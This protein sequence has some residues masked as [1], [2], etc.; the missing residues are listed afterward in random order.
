[1]LTYELQQRI[2]RREK[3]STLEFPNE[4]QVEIKLGPPQIFGAMDGPSRGALYKRKA[5]L[6]YNANTGRTLIQSIPP[7]EPLYVSINLE[8]DVFEL[9]GDTLC[10]K[11]QCEDVNILFNFLRMTFYLLPPLL[12]VSFPD[13]PVILYTKGKIGEA[14]FTWELREAT[15]AFDTF[16]KESLEHHIQ[17]A[18]NNFTLFSGTSN[19]RLA[20]GI[21][22]F[23]TASRLICT[24]NSNWEFCAESILN[25]CKCLEIVFGDSR[26]DI[27]Q[28]LQNLGYGRNEI[29]GDFIALTLLRD[30]LDVAHPRVA[31][32]NAEHL[33]VLYQY[34]PSAE[35]RM[36]DLIQRLISAVSDG[37]YVLRQD[38][39]L[40]LNKTE[41]KNMD[42]LI[43]TIKA[44]ITPI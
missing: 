19:R 23:H 9:E 24:G 41:Q 30:E 31:M 39:D 14:E 35:N 21:H 10:C 27:R 26:D 13:P 11:I 22:Y 34:L 8:D 3:G 5:R 28:G 25:M 1:M 6:E 40:R 15:G 44:R 33:R 37:S 17:Q 18:I 32:F 38:A 4:V 2:L 12:N 7:L 42:R 20:A 43:E 29:E 16:T 36:R